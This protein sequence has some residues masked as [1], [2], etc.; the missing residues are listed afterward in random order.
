MKPF[1]DAQAA[2]LAG[3][4]DGDG[5]FS[6]SRSKRAIRPPPHFALGIQGASVAE[7]CRERMNFLNERGTAHR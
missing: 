5:N 1:S 4:I 2:Y 7:A 6:I 3:L